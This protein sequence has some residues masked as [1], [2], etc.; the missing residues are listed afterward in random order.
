LA[1]YE[2]IEPN[3][4]TAGSVVLLGIFGWGQVGRI[5]LSHL[6]ELLQA[7]KIG[8]CS[9]PALP[10]VL[11][12]EG[13]GFSRLPC[14]EYYFSKRCVPK[15][16]IV[17]GDVAI[18]VFN[19]RQFY[20]T[21]EHV[22]SLAKRIGASQLIAVD[23]R[24]GAEGEKIKVFASRPSLAKRSAL[25]SGEILEQGIIESYSGIAVGLARMYSL[26]AIGVVVPCHNSAPNRRAGMLAFRYL[27]NLL[28]LKEQA[29]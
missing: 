9:T 3:I 7:T 18:S 29:D 27:V 1:F 17:T 16:F 28:D 21:I 26:D 20:G 22:V 24:P 25:P 23:G 5:S 6:I 12:S 4:E 15:I 11:L 19:R 13:D 8:E 10:D 14:I 2:R